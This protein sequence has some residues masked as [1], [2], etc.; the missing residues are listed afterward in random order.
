[1]SYTRNV[2]KSINGT[3][4]FTS[5]HM[6]LAVNPPEFPDIT[7]WGHSETWTSPVACAAIANVTGDCPFAVL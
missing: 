3:T 7:K 6:S 2:R 1:M 5:F 4:F